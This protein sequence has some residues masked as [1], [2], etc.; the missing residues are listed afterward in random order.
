MSRSLN[1]PQ[2]WAEEIAKDISTEP[3]AQELAL[4]YAYMALEDVNYH[5]ENRAMIQ[6]FGEFD[7]RTDYIM[8][9]VYYDVTPG[10]SYDWDPDVAFELAI[11]VAELN[12]PELASWLKSI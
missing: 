11:I 7:D 10:S 5:T 9:G 1:T 2:G 4:G 12:H 3:N 6:K 8:S